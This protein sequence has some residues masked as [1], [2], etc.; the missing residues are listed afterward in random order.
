VAPPADDDPAL[1]GRTGRPVPT[2]KLF[3]G[4]LAWLAAQFLA[5][6]MTGAGHGWGTPFLVSLPLSV[7]Y[8]LLV[9]R[10]SRAPP[11]GGIRLELGVAAV[12]LFLDYIL[13]TSIL[14]DEAV[15]FSR[16]WKIDSGLVAAWLILWAG[17][18]ALLLL[19]F[20]RNRSGLA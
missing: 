1:Q 16:M 9:L 18:H 13:W 3:C 6:L 17:W 5:L 20:R 8:P 11:G 2:L 4:F 19:A 12:A 14:D 10:A 15:F 7:L